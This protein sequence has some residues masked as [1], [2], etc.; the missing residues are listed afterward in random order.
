M[1]ATHNNTRTRKR[2]K[3]NSNVPL[4]ISNNDSRLTMS[5]IHQQLAA[6]LQLQHQG[7]NQEAK[8]IYEWLLSGDPNN[9]DAL[10]LLGSLVL[11]DGEAQQ[12][13]NLLKRALKINP[14][15][16]NAHYNLGLA[17]SKLNRHEEAI[18]SYKH[19]IDLNSRDADAYNDRGIS[20]QKLARY[21]EALKSHKQAIEIEPRHFRA[22]NNHGLALAYLNRH[23]EALACYA[24]SLEIKPDYAEA[25]NNR[26][27]LLKDLNQLEKAFADFNTALTIKPDYPEAFLGRGNVYYE[28]FLYEEAIKDYERALAVN[29][30]L[31]DAIHNRGGAHKM[32]RRLDEA[33]ADYA[34]A[35]KLKPDYDFLPGKK[36]S[37]QLEVCD[38]SDLQVQID[39]L[40][41]DIR[42]EKKSSEPFSLL[43]IIDKPELHRRA[44]DIY[45]KA[46][47]PISSD[48]PCSPLRKL[49]AKI[50]IGYFSADFHN[51][52]TAY[53][54]AELFEAHDSS[55]F[56]LHAFSF[57]P[58]SD[59][60]MRQ[61]LVDAFDHFH[62]VRASSDSEVAALSRKMQIDIAVDLKGYTLHSRAGIFAQRCAP[63]QIN[64][65]GYPGTMASSYFDYIIADEVLIPESSRAD[66]SEKVIYLP[67]SYQVNDSKRQIARRPIA[68][69]EM[70]LP[71]DAF[72]F[73]CFNN[74]YKIQPS[75]FDVWMRLLAQIEGSV[76]WLLEDNRL[77]AENLRK[78]ALLRGI[79]PHRLVFAARCPLD[80]H[81]A[82]HCLADLFIDTLP[83]NAH[84]TASDALWGGLPVLT[85]A[86][87][88]FP[89]RVA[90]SLLRALDLDELVTSTQ[91]AYEAR[92]IELATHS[93]MLRAIRSKLERNRL[94]APLFNGRLF[95][96]HIEAAYASAIERQ[97][98]GLVPD[99]IRIEP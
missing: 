29:P 12:A 22:L 63:I 73:C 82:R 36:L 32:L 89:A 19:T 35:L 50:K 69:R 2:H 33:L 39:Q 34:L 45:A 74:N 88:S 79:D 18:D 87:R 65:L 76:L 47:F 20:L 62:H 46:R 30:N 66:Y 64:Y 84:T 57:G 72:V 85:C 6:G 23:E 78:E 16:P 61:R 71:E 25:Y 80:E 3:I 43:G 75:T 17:L 51:H 54:M 48:M 26:G 15:Y 9:F 8:A 94:T 44:A 67:H 1:A 38:W 40:E 86:G 95:A 93:E 41:L 13:V 5:F 27:N 55:K 81:L 90:A 4:S 60:A 97:R 11:R 14:R 70:G 28:L 92:A 77:A 98:S 31:V 52:A 96:G 91:N 68:R 99:H 56:E 21:S 42:R 37:A 24:R 49:G 59:D 53:L 7:R 58:H 10:Q 83:C